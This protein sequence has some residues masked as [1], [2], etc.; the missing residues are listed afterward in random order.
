[1]LT[2]RSTGLGAVITEDGGIWRVRKREKMPVVEVF[3][4]EESGHGDILSDDF[5][6]WRSRDDR[7][8]EVS[9]P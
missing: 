6:K 3:K 5:V 9:M 4:V 7:G 2:S 8:N 1:M